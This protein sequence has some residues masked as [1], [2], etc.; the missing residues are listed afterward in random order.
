MTPEQWKKYST[1]STYFFVGR[2]EDG[3]LAWDSFKKL[4]RFNP[5]DHHEIKVMTM[6]AKFKKLNVYALT[7]EKDLLDSYIDD[8][9]IPEIVLRDI[10][11]RAVKIYPQ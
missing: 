6:T 2:I 5:A 10:T 3:L 9:D 7:T 4:D 8:N 11:P 1:T